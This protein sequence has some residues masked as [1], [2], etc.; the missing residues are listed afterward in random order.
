MG[1]DVGLVAKV[2]DSRTSRGARGMFVSVVT[3]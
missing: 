3:R 2:G 1:A